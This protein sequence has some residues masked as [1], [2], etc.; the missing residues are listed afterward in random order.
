[1][2]EV[3]VIS[4]ELQNAVAQEISKM[5]RE[6]PR[7]SLAADILAPH[8]AEVIDGVCNLVDTD[9][10]DFEVAVI[11]ALSKWKHGHAQ[12]FARRRSSRTDPFFR[13]YARN[14]P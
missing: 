6:H 13:P 9:F 3:V 2:S 8:L 10:P 11:V 4:D 12:H 5:A 7:S 14:T 1:M